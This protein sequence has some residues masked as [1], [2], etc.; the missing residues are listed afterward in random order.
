MKKSN[1]STIF[2]FFQKNKEK[3]EE[4][5]ITK[6][7]PKKQISKEDLE[8]YEKNRKE[9]LEKQKKSQ[10]QNI[11]ESKFFISSQ[12]FEKTTSPTNPISPPV[13][14]NRKRKL[15]SP[16]K[17][18]DSE[19]TTPINSPIKRENSP[20]KKVISLNLQE[21]KE[22]SSKKIKIE[23]KNKESNKKEMPPKQEVKK[24]SP[25]KKTT[26]KT[27]KND[28]IKS[29]LKNAIDLNNTLEEDSK[30]DKKP[31]FL[32]EIKDANLNPP[33][34]PHYDPST[35][36][37]PQQEYNKLTSTRKQYWDVKRNNFDKI[38][39][40]QIG[41]FYELFY[42]DAELGN[43]LFGLKIHTAH[44]GKI[45]TYLSKINNL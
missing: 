39:A 9:A 13:L 8:K 30:D 15:E 2:Q 1:Q 23:E 38:V 35:L 41:S 44:S 40:I 31:S 5:E 21:K 6:K 42:N 19:K 14:H 25:F 17:N 24:E 45:K 3:S 29:K 7:P 18:K 36:Y 26:S 20:Q 43:K 28:E 32:I 11:K 33:H 4:E 10:T 27:S 12:K 37:I 16:E 34:S 22:E